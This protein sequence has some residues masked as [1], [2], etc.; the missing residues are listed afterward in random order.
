MSWS[1]TAAAPRRSSARLDVGRLL[2]L[3]LLGV[4]C[5]SPSGPE[6]T[7][8]QK[9]ALQTRE[10]EGEKRQVFNAAVNALQGSGYIVSQADFDTGLITARSETTRPT[11]EGGVSA[12]VGKAVSDVL[13]GRGSELSS[14]RAATVFFE[15]LAPGRV[16]VRAAFV[17]SSQRARTD[18]EGRHTG[19]WVEDTAVYD[20]EVYRAFFDSLDKALFVM[21]STRD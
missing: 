8:L 5:A 4:S 19:Q 2:L 20:P 21:K 13:A 14:Q 18:L 11:L 6:L 12:A 15:E 16:R 1:T 17:E 9:E 10:F 3:L 7:S